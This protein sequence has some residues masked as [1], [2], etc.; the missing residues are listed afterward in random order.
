VGKASGALVGTATNLNMTG[1]MQAAD[2][3][4]PSQGAL[5]GTGTIN[6]TTFKYNY[7]DIE[8]SP[9]TTAIGGVEDNYKY[10]DYIRGSKT[11]ILKAVN[12]YIV[13]DD[14]LSKMS[15]KFKAE[16]YGMAPWKAM[17]LGIA[18]YNATDAVKGYKC[19]LEYEVSDSYNNRY[20]VLTKK[21][22]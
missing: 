21:K 11:H 6:K 22:L 1:C 2:G 14:I 12:D 19:L 15:K 20:P 4:A 18:I 17:N 5:L 10:D 8:L 3:I 7:Y 9:N 13:S 16:V